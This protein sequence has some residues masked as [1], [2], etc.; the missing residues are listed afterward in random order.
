MHVRS[1]FS[2]LCVAGTVLVTRG[3]CKIANQ[4]LVPGSLI[5]PICWHTV[6]RRSDRRS[7]KLLPEAVGGAC[8]LPEFFTPKWANWIDST[9]SVFSGSTNTF[10][11]LVLIVWFANWISLNQFALIYFVVSSIS[12]IPE[13]RGARHLLNRVA[14]WS[15][16][17]VPAGLHVSLRHFLLSKSFHSS[18]GWRKRQLCLFEWKDEKAI[19]AMYFSVSVFFGGTY[20][21]WSPDTMKTNSYNI[22]FMLLTYVVPVT[23]MAV[24]YSRMGFVL[25]GSR[26]IGEL[27]HRQS[28]SIRSK[29]KVRHINPTYVIFSSNLN[30]L[31]RCESHKSF[32]YALIL[33]RC[34]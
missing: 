12:Q 9:D 15:R 17:P 2:A 26:G 29:R 13:R 10:V 20:G 30:M 27:S 11:N 16:P 28:E 8:F 1:Q 34:F 19:S 25:W 32:M 3:H 33:I 14:R 5:P 21:R 4:H 22:I 18:I 23:A 6:L 31:C 24:C 7:A